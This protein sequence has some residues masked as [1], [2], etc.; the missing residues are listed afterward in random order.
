MYQLLEEL[1]LTTTA[2]ER[3]AILQRNWALEDEY[4]VLKKEKVKLD[5]EF[6]TLHNINSK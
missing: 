1:K 4:A 5:S 2:A 6:K 3:F